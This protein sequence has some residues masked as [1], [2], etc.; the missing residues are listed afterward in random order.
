MRWLSWML[1]DAVSTFGGEIDSIYYVI[2]WITG[3]VFVLVEVALITF[4][5]RYRH[6]EGRKAVFTHGSKKAE[7]VWTVIPFFIVLFIAFTS[8]RVWLEVKV[9]DRTHV[10][11]NALPLKVTAKQFEWNVTYPGPDGK[12]DTADD[13]TKRNQLHLPLD[14][15]VLVELRSEDVIHSFFLPAFRVKQDA[16]PGM[17]MHVWF[18]PTKAGEYVLGCAELCGLGHYR[19][20]GTVTVH[21]RGDFERWEAEEGAAAGATQAT[22]PSSASEGGQSKDGKEHA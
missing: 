14:R 20:R 10:P 21:E 7:V 12:I 18:Q 13:F 15:A 11:A 22:A 9:A 17:V 4:L 6:R 16:V 3:I 1:P 19:M 5:I 8:N 2:L